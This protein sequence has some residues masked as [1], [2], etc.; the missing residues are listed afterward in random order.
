MLKLLILNLVKVT[1][2]EPMVCTAKT[3]FESLFFSPW[4]QL[5]TALELFSF[6]VSFI[7]SETLIFHNNH[8]A[9]HIGLKSYSAYYELHIKFND[10][11]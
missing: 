2:D 5:S 7:W 9:L 1:D 3:Y 10:S 6:T 4:P 8:L 11:V